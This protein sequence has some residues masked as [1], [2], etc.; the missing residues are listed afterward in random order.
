VKGAHFTRE[1]V[2]EFIILKNMLWGKVLKFKLD[3]TGSG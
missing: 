1:G 2:G 3:R